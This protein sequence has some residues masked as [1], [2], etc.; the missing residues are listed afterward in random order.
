MPGLINFSILPQTALFGLFTTVI[1][2]WTR[3]T[4][5]TCFFIEGSLSL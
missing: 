1:F 3:R 5:L 2:H 4:F